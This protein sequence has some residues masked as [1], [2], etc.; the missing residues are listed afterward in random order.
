M[1]LFIR[2]KDVREMQ[3]DLRYAEQKAEDLSHLIGVERGRAQTFAR[4]ADLWKE[5]AEHW[6]IEAS[7]LSAQLQKI[8]HK[9]KAAEK[10]GQAKEKEP[11]TPQLMTPQNPAYRT[12]DDA[13]ANRFFFGTALREA[14]AA[15]VAANLNKK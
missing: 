5:R 11:A 7:K 12:V 10:G 13:D 9:A 8:R 15:A 2:G 3:R 14:A 4:E 1:F 6:Q